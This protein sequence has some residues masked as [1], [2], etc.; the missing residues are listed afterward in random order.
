MRFIK[1]MAKDKLHYINLDN[2]TSISPHS[3]KQF[4]DS[5]CYVNFNDGREYGHRVEMSMK[6]FVTLIEEYEIGEKFEKIV[7]KG[8]KV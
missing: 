5:V 1:F 6:E 7:L 4:K 2:V 8:D 3:D